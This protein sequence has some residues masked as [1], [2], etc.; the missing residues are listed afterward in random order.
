MDTRLIASLIISV[1][2]HLSVGLAAMK[3]FSPGQNSQ[4]ITS[5]SQVP[6]LKTSPPSATEGFVITPSD[7]GADQ[8]NDTLH[9]VKRGES[10]WVIAREYQVTIEEIM[11]RNGLSTE[12]VLKVGDNLRI[13]HR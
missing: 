10:L 4:T 8:Q 6:D 7:T 13:P 5:D 1:V 11:D 2:F 9:T 3:V 12:H